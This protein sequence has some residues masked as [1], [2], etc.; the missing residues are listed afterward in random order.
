MDGTA[1]AT[2]LVAE[3][4]ALVAKVSAALLADRV[5]VAVEALETPAAAVSNSM[6]I[7]GVA[8]DTCQA[9]PKLLRSA[10]K[11]SNLMFHWF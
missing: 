8:D 7:S 3:A 6:A 9:H 5:S 11:A 2:A 1:V 4:Q 10:V